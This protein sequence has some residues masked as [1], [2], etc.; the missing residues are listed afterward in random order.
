MF[1]VPYKYEIVN[2]NTLKLRPTKGAFIAT[3]VF[4]A[5]TVGLQFAAARKMESTLDLTL[6]TDP[7]FTDP[8]NN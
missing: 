5:L 6:A 8:T 1:G 4:T 3:A 7:R 2:D